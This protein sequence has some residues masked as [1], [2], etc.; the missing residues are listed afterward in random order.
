MY[1]VCVIGGGPAG[2]FCA[3]KLLELVPNIDITIF[4]KNKPLLSLL[5]TGNGRC[6]LAYNEY[7][8]KELASHY[9][10]GEKFLYSIFSRYSLSE[11]LADFEKI[12]VKAYAQDDSRIFPIEN[13]A[14]YVRNKMLQALNNRVKFITKSVTNL[15]EGFDYYVLATGLKCGAGLAEKLGH[16]IVPL[17][18]SLCGLKIKEREFLELE[19]VSFNGVIFTKEGISGPFVYKVSSINAYRDFPYEIKIPLININDL[20]ISVLQNPKKLFRNIVSEFIPKS[21]A[22][23]LVKDNI[24]CANTKKETIK[25]LEYLKLTAAGCDNKGEIVHAGGVSLDNVDKNL[26]S[27]VKENVWIIGELLDIDGFTG[28]FNLQN[29]WSTASI[30][31]AD[32]AA[33]VNQ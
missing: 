17:K 4:D 6:N 3:I 16:N 19:G 26:K 31:A 9:P 2:I 11:T 15:P 12:G 13:K 22:S 25:S 8:F 32:I 1:K 14:S 18:S 27:K 29:C 33:K 30:A 20:E 10:R 21:L 28:G 23:I 24:Q 7:D 5:P